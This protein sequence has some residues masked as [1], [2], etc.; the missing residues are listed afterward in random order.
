MILVEH[1]LATVQQLPVQAI[2][3]QRVI[4]AAVVVLHH[5]RKQV[6][7]VAQDWLPRLGTSPRRYQPAQSEYDTE[8]CRQSAAVANAAAAPLHLALYQRTFTPSCSTR[9]VVSRL[10]VAAGKTVPKFGSFG[11]VLKRVVRKLK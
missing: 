3:T 10:G 1:A 11:F 6:R 2:Q 7:F 8:R 9:G 5:V 4:Q